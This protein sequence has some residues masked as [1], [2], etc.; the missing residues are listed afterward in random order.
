MNNKIITIDGPS[1]SGK[2]TIAKQ[3]ANILGFNYL[4]SGALYRIT[5]YILTQINNN[6]NYHYPKN[7]E[8]I[9]KYENEIITKFTNS[10][11]LFT[12]INDKDCILLNNKNITDLI[13][14]EEIGKIASI[15]ASKINIRKSLLEWQRNCANENG[16]VTDGRDMGTVVFPNAKCK[17]FLIADV[18]KR[19]L[20][21]YQQL[22][23][24]IEQKTET[25]VSFSDVLN[26][27]KQRDERDI[28]R[29]TAPLKPADDAL[30]IDNT[31]LNIEETVNKVLEYY[32]SL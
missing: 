1:A 2:G 20:R 18:E 23:Q 8:D 7:N 17:I 21:R 15:L 32:R 11:I 25:A 24:S 13:R 30:I 3:I 22:Q 10:K 5:A 4:D 12:Q 31:N 6:I 16:L 28:S 29:S 14:T 9:E 26:N 19:A 27:L